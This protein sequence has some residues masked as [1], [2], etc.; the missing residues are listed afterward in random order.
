MTALVG[1]GAPA[2]WD[3]SGWAQRLGGVV[4]SAQGDVDLDWERAA[5]RTAAEEG[6]PLLSV[7]VAATEVLIGPLWTADGRYPCAGCAHAADEYRQWPTEERFQRDRAA[8]ERRAGAPPRPAGAAERLG[9]AAAFPPWLAGAVD[10]V[11]SA[12]PAGGELVA[13]G[14][15]GTVTRYRLR[16]T[17]R[18]RVCAPPQPP[19]LLPAPNTAP[20]PDLGDELLP[21]RRFITKIAGVGPAPAGLVRR[22]AGE[23]VPTRGRRAP[24]GMDSGRM[25]AAVADPRFGPVTRMTRHSAG[26]FPISEVEMLV[27]TPAGLG[28]SGTWGES[29]AV[30]VLEAYERMAGYPHAAPILPDTT[31][32]E[33]GALALDPD[34]LGRHTARQLAHPTSRLQPY[35]VDTPVDWVWA[36]PLG[37]GEPRLVPAEIGFFRYRYDIRPGPDGAP[38]RNC[39]LESSSGSALGGSREEAALHSLL[40]LAERDAFLLAWHRA[41]PLPEIDLAS[42]T[43]PYSRMLLRMADERGYDVHLLAATADIPVPVVWALAVNRRRALPASF[44]TA[45][46]HPDPA[47]AVRSA[48][49]EVS[50]MVATGLN[51]DP[52]E[53]EP[54][55][56][57]PWQ[58]ET[59]AQHWRRYAFPELLPRVERV[60]GGPRRTLAE[61]FPGWPEALV[62]AAGGDVTG[63]LEYVA[64]LYRRAGLDEILL[65]DQSTV[66]IQD[67]GMA[68]VK[69]V[70]P[71]VVPMCFG[72][73]HQRLAGL[74]RLGFADD[75]VPLDPHPFP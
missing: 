46:C 34:R 23:A 4:L 24:F 35:T 69:C 33:L 5:L 41:R 39:F 6:R 30:A 64:E 72:H 59:I 17:F 68:V 22:P 21:G 3:W 66:D 43:D 44:S 74:S 62:E 38:R 27:G 9:T 49:W 26:V 54:L 51:W 8:R 56:D 31:V 67:V 75:D 53:L 36:S 42:V 25:R 58:V 48:L 28:R 63:S 71:G 1:P 40:E 12:P 45:G 37:A 7:R 18:C 16:R 32:R 15:T 73:A 60:L 13:I 47:Q 2:G 52:A 29:E 65:V 19:L 57:D 20:R 11:L 50:Q 61:A 14:R 70:V 55:I 10:A